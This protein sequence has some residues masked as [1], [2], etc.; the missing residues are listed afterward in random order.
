M[1]RRASSSTSPILIAVVVIVVVALVIA[2]KFLLSKK[3]ES[4]A[5]VKPL[6]VHYLQEDGNSLRMSKWLVEGVVD[7]RFFKNGTSTSIVSVRVKSNGGEIPIPIKIPPSLSN[8]NI[9]RE[10][11]YAFKVEFQEGGIP[12]A[13]AI[14]RL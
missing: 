7:E 12:V 8:T 13:I 11:R 5:D 1:A 6:P 3:S 2:G 14:K 10:Q 9:E 4:F